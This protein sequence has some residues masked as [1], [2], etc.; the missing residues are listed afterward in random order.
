MS[1]VAQGLHYTVLQEQIH[2]RL[3]SNSIVDLIIFTRW[4]DVELAERLQS[5]A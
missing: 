2:F 1:K 5:F 4:P 3:I